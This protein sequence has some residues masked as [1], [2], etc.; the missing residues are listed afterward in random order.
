MS[1]DIISRYKSSV[2]KRLDTLLASNKTLYEIVRDA[3]RYSVNIGGKRI[4]PCLLLEF[5]NICNSR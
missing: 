1:K 3:M 5:A 4:R 2:D